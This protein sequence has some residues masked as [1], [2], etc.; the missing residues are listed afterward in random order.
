M[1][2]VTRTTSVI[3]KARTIIAR[4]EN[5]LQATATVNPDVLNTLILAKMTVKGLKYTRQR[6]EKSREVIV[7]PESL[8]K[9]KEGSKTYWAKQPPL[10]NELMPRQSRSVAN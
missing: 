7:P 5:H 2:P 9:Q 8:H 3:G 6:I 4:I 1:P 10:R